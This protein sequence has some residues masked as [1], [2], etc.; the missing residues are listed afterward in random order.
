MHYSHGESNMAIVGSD[1][2]ALGHYGLTMALLVD[3]DPHEFTTSIMNL[4]QPHEL[5]PLG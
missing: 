4:P 1:V 5:T 3:H 2:E